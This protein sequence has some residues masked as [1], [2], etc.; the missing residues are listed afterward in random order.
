[1]TSTAPDTIEQAA[2]DAAAAE[3]FTRRRAGQGPETAVPVRDP[4]EEQTFQTWLDADPRHQEAYQ[5]MVRTFDDILWS[6]QSSTPADEAPV[7]RRSLAINGYLTAIVAVAIVAIGG[8]GLVV[9]QFRVKSTGIGETR[10][11][12]LDDGSEIRL[13][14]KSAVDVRYDRGERH[15]ILKYGEAYFN[16][17][18]DAGRPFHVTVGDMDV[19]DIGTRFDINRRTASVEVSVMEG[20]VEVTATKGIQAQVAQ[21]QARPT[22]LGTGDTLRVAPF[23]HGGKLA[24]W[25]VRK[26]DMTAQGDTGESG[27]MIYDDAPLGD[28]VD[29]INRY[30][31]P[32]VTLATPELAHKRLTTALTAK[33]INT[34]LDTLPLVADVTLHRND[35]GS[36][37]ILQRNKTDGEKS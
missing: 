20:Q 3:W 25:Q 36:V 19:R 31:A 28:I 17:A 35:D 24:V 13:S 32:G 33:D 30:Y 21:N 16:V 23:Q 8:Y 4:K 2:I 29:D 27:R 12:V 5:L 15:I 34:F 14:A 18:H 10:T 6:I 1:V 7:T 37:V 9:P 11:V 22:L 26:T